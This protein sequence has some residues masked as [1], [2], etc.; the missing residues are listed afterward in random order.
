MMGN[1]N[2]QESRTLPALAIPTC[3]RTPARL[4]Q[5]VVRGPAWKWDNQDG[6]D[7]HVGTLIIVEQP[8]S[9]EEEN[10][11]FCVRVVWDNGKLCNYRASPSKECDL[12]LFDSGPVGVKFP[13]IICDICCTNGIVG[14]RWK[15]DE[16]IDYDLCHTCYMSDKHNLQHAFLRFDEPGAIGVKVPPRQGSVKVEVHGIFEGAKVERGAHWKWGNQDGG[17]GNIGIVHSICNWGS[18]TVRSEAR[19]QWPPGTTEYNYRVGHGGDVDLQCTVPASG[20]HFYRDHMPLIAPVKVRHHSSD[21]TSPEYCEGDRIAITLDLECFKVLQEGHGGW[22][23]RMKKIVNQMGTVQ[24]VN[25]DGDVRVSFNSSFRWTVNPVALVKVP[26]F[27]PG[28]VVT[29][30]D[31]EP[32]VRSLQEGH[33]GF[34]GPMMMCLGK[35]GI[36][37]KVFHSHDVY[38]LFGGT[39]WLYNPLCLNLLARRS[40]SDFRL[41]LTELASGSDIP[42]E[43]TRRLLGMIL[44]ASQHTSDLNTVNR[45][46][47]FSAGQRVKICSDKEMV[48]R[49]QQG[50]GGY[51][52]SMERY[53]GQ[54]GKIIKVNSCGDRISIRFA[55][56]VTTW[57]YNPE[58]VELV[59]GSDESSDERDS[60]PD[61]VVEQRL[62]RMIH[63]LLDVSKE[64]GSGT[65]DKTKAFTPTTLHS[66]C[67]TGNEAIVRMMAETGAN[68]E[69]EDGDGDRALHY[70]TYGGQANIIELLLNLGVEINATNKKMVTALQVAVNK[71]Y[72]SCVRILINNF[73]ERLDVN[74]QDS[75]GDTP[76]HYAIKHKSLEITD[77]LMNFPT[78]DFTLCNE[79]GYNILHQ[80][81]AV[82]NNFATERILSKKTDLV[83]M[84]DKD[85]C[86]ALHLAAVANNYS[87]AKTLVAQGKCTVDLK[88]T[89]Q[90][91]ALFMAV[92]A[93]NC[94]LVELLL[95]VGADINAT[96]K[97]GDTPMHMSLAMR[98][99]LLVQ[100][101]SPLQ[102]PAITAIVRKLLE[103]P[104]P[105]VYSTWALACF[106]ASKGADLHRKNK[107]GKTPLEM[108][109]SAAAVELLLTWRTQKGDAATAV[110]SAT[111]AVDA[112][113]AVS[114]RRICKICLEADA[115]V[116][117]EPCGH[118]LYCSECC[119]RMKR[120]LE[121]SVPI[122]GRVS[123]SERLGSS[124]EAGR[125][126]QRELEARLQQLEEVHS[127]G[128]C[129]ERQRNVVFLCGHGAC[130]L[131]A[132]DLQNCH[133]CRETLTKKIKV[134]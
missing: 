9:E 86:T 82:G 87:V 121:C 4:G 113:Y 107:D 101:L 65:T 8:W 54:V 130:D 42:E 95:G 76:L 41:R 47:R 68:L 45:S 15:C 79:S 83:D 57:C 7:G 133:M 102:A 50:H 89:Q 43:I 40:E 66:A 30:I 104:Q 32:R 85:G 106:L 64:Q 5:R 61:T 91:T 124:T 10:S 75:V 14:T 100:S 119:R 116:W 67:F 12:R 29:V 92:V 122:T 94:E 24:S 28:D 99:D 97:Y 44:S 71:Q 74:T 63:Q 35:K 21:S 127:C 20:G 110:A 129:M 2:S 59:D 88:N 37:L 26:V 132:A 51:T 72:V 55:G 13:T 128:I 115:E 103:N 17:T 22:N 112:D 62:E 126:A 108:A 48:K 93:G 125:Q 19:V 73:P 31:D 109:G 46:S 1:N 118:H 96:D 49:L 69:E 25:H 131:C 60:D 105:E 34:V 84:K 11:P 134:Y 80:A 78:V 36:V 58:C 111:S 23:P 123:V 6:G 53:L 3:S 98:S 70:A 114:N 90:Q 81:A 33:G 27:A 16:C 39:A 18:G 117:F 38:V 52:D 120:C 77:M 56:E